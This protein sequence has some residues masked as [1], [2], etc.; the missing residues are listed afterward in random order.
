MVLGTTRLYLAAAKRG[1]SCA[2]VAWNSGAEPAVSAG[3]RSTISTE[4][5]VAAKRSRRGPSTGETR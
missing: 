2:S 3:L 1:A 5:P 4:M